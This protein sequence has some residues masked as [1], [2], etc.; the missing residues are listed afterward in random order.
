VLVDNIEQL[1]HPAIGRLVEL[2]V[3]CPDLA[4]ALRPQALRPQALRRGGGDLQA[5]ALVALTRDAQPFLT[6]EPLHVLAVHG[7]SLLT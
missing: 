6:P 7:P 2:E 4:R 3:E 1:Q 5:L